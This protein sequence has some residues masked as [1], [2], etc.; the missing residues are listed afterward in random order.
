MNRNVFFI[1]VALAILLLMGCAQQGMS[2]SCQSTMELQIA[3]LKKGDSCT[4][5]TGSGCGGTAEHSADL[6]RKISALSEQGWNLVTESDPWVSDSCPNPSPNG[7][8]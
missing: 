6:T 4:V 5:V 1:A 3:V 8:E 2:G 7:L